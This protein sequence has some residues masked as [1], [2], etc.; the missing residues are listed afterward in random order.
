MRMIGDTEPGCVLH[1]ISDDTDLKH[2]LQDFFARN[3]GFK[4]HNALDD[5]LGLRA[6]MIARGQVS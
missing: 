2:R 5:A 4:R 6:A 3:P 1:L